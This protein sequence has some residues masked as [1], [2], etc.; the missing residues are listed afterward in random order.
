MKVV[1]LQL[2]FDLFLRNNYGNDFAGVFFCGC[3]VKPSLQ[4][5][6]APLMTLDSLSLKRHFQK[7][8]TARSTA[9]HS[10]ADSNG[11]D[12]AVAKVETQCAGVT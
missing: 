3:Q 10:N 1:Q 9:T 12:V 2:T 7:P 6:F 8:Q 5:V 11:R 4:R